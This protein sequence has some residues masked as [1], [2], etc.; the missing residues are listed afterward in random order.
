MEISPS[1]SPP[2]CSVTPVV[3]GQRMGPSNVQIFE[4]LDRN[5]LSEQAARRQ[6]AAVKATSP[7]L[8]SA[9]RMR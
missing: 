3:L 9:C 2:D 6:A 7:E 4:V 1:S 5:A 8:G